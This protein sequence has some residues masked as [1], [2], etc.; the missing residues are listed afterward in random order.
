TIRGVYD[1]HFVSLIF[2]I[3]S[4]VPWCLTVYSTLQSSVHV[5][6]WKCPNVTTIRL[7]TTIQ[8]TLVGRQPQQ[9]TGQGD[10]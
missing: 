2:F 8:P 5:H 1:S 10:G 9:F 6:K 4:L 3:R 7:A